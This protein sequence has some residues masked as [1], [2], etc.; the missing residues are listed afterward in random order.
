[1]GPLNMLAN[2]YLPDTAPKEE[3]EKAE[4]RAAKAVKILE[5]IAEKNHDKPVQASALFAIANVYKNKA[6]PYGKSP[7]ADA[8][9]LAKQAET[10]FERIEKEFADVTQ[11]RD[12]TYGAAAKAALFEL[13]NLRV[14]KTVPEIEGEDVDGVKFKLSDYRGKVV[15]L[16]FWG[17]W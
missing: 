10:R 9:E 4:A 12:L 7:P 5:Q 3:V 8:D 14:G 2:P 15:M 6:E 11:F 1:M 13:R 17:H 16:D